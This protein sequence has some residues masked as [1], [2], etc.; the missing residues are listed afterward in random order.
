[1]PSK[2]I[3]KFCETEIVNTLEKTGREYLTR[4]EKKAI[5]EKVLDTL[6]LRIP[7][8]PH[9]YDVV[10]QLEESWLWFFSNLKAA[11]EALEIL[12]QNAFNLRLIRMFPYT[13]ASLAADLSDMEKDLLPQLSITNFAG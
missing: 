11:N 7:A 6:S 4:N 12:F 2:V 1:M 5:K 3:K 13:L 10:W 9:I 8:T